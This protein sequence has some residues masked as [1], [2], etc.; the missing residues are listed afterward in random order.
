VLASFSLTTSLRNK[1]LFVRKIKSLG[2]R[3][4]KDTK[5]LTFAF[6]SKLHYNYL[7]VTTIHSYFLY[8][9]RYYYNHNSQNVKPPLPST[10]SLIPLF[11]NNNIIFYKKKFTK[12][13]I[14]N[15]QRSVSF[16]I[17]LCIYIYLGRSTYSVREKC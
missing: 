6:Y 17:C 2:T 11:I 1:G 8:C 14:K 15:L 12:N 3:Q 5:L 16:P 4:G 10:L 13:K 7:F 9:H